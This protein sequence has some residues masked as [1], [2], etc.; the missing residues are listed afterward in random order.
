[1]SSLDS[2]GTRQNRC[3]ADHRVVK[4]PGWSTEIM[5]SII[6]PTLDHKRLQA[7]VEGNPGPLG[8]GSNSSPAMSQADALSEVKSGVV[9]RCCAAAIVGT[10][11]AKTQAKLASAMITNATRIRLSAWLAS[12]GIASAS[13]WPRFFG[14]PERRV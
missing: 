12:S 10:T 5:T 11:V 14:K 9:A 6:L 2:R 8:G 1:M 7:F 3:I 13:P 4:A